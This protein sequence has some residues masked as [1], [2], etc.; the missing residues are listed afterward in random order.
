MVPFGCP[1]GLLAADRACTDQ[2]TAHFSQPARLLGY[3]PVLDHKK[4]HRG[5]QGTHHGTLLA[6]GS[7][8]RHTR[9]CHC[10]SG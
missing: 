7:L 2:T 8:A 5:I 4:E 3:R 6:D 10:Q 9:P 1:T